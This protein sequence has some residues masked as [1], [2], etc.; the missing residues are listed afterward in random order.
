[1]YYIFDNGGKTCDRYAVLIE[2][3][4]FGMSEDALSPQGFNQYCCELSELSRQNLGQ[5]VNYND[6]PFQ[7]QKAIKLRLNH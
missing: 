1:M 2:N 4:V 3:S 7:V 6:L 5:E